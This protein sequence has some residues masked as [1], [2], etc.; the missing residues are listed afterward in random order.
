MNTDLK[1]STYAIGPQEN[2]L[3]IVGAQHSLVVNTIKP[4]TEDGLQV[5]GK[6]RMNGSYS[7]NGQNST[8]CPITVRGRNISPFSITK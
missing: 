7:E 8:Y 1:G 5:L 6:E 2:F 3:F 4:V